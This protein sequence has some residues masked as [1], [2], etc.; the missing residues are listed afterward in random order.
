MP[1]RRA[2]IT[3]VGV[4]SS[5]CDNF[6]ELEKALK[7]GVYGI[8]E[9]PYFDTSA[10][11]LNKAGV[12]KSIPKDFEE[13][14]E[15]EDANNFALHCLDEAL[16][17]ADLKPEIYSPERIGVSLASSNAGENSRELFL[18][19]TGANED[20]EHLITESP[21]TNAGI[22]AKKVNAHGPRVSIS[23]ACAAGG[24]SIGCAYDMIVHDECDMVVTGG[25][26]PLSKLSFSGFQILNTISEDEVIPFDENRHGIDMGEAGALFIV[27]SLDSALKRNAK[28]Y[29]EIIGYGISNDAYHTSAPDPEAVGAVYAIKQCMEQ[30]GLVNS[31]VDYINAHGTGTKYNDAMELKAITDVFGEGAK[32]IA[33]SSSKSMHG[34]TLAAAGSLELAVCLVAIKD[35]FIPKTIHT[36]Q[37]MNGYEDYKIVTEQNAKSFE[38][39]EVDVVLSNSFGFAG[40]NTCLAIRKYH[41][42]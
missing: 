2:V 29:A 24:N 16:R 25:V 22:V 17:D 6:E 5:I 42:D 10:Y 8:R 30:S 31:D 39:Y 26:D 27:E 1:K 18:R 21:S 41:N 38:D 11:K 13:Y 23:T 28:I 34:H 15:P 9:V 37:I 32:N 33:V 20:V 12:L 19:K 40:N 4:I 3:G 7:E 35:R 14:N 36:G